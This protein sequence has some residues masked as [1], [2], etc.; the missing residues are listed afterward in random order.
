M[1][2]LP[3]SLPLPEVQARVRMRATPADALAAQA[4]TDILGTAA[5]ILRDTREDIYDG[6]LDDKVDIT[7]VQHF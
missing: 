1:F 2:S 6:V 7:R 5:Q 4:A 3:L